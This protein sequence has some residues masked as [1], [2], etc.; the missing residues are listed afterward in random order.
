MKGISLG[1]LIMLFI[2]QQPARGSSCEELAKIALPHTKIT[3]AQVVGAGKFL[4]PGGAAGGAQFPGLLA[5]CRVTAV[6][7]PTEQS[8]TKIDVWLPMSGWNGKF[9]PGSLGAG[10]PG[11]I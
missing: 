11:G 8:D 4:P 3:S 10:I 6:S 1:F 9:Q 7:K 2:P 5:F